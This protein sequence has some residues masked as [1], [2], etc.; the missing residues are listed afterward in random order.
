MK[1]PRIICLKCGGLLDRISDRDE[2]RCPE[3]KR[4]WDN[5]E[6]LR[7]RLDG[8]LESHGVGVEKSGDATG[9]R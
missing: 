8:N 1:E 2:S 3:C 9:E 4:L 6:L 7:A 5:L